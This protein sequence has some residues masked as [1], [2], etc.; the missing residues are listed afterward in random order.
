MSSVVHPGYVGI[1]TTPPGADVVSTP[2]NTATGLSDVT[3][4]PVKSVVA[5]EFINSANVAL[6]VSRFK[7]SNGPSVVTISPPGA[8][9]AMGGLPRILHVG[10]TVTCVFGFVPTTVM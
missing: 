10:R 6:S 5:L 7:T 4:D 8:V 3:T 2:E 9:A 1:S